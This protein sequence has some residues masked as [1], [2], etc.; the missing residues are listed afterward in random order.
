MIL[1]PSLSQLVKLVLLCLGK[2]GDRKVRVLVEFALS[3]EPLVKF[4]MVITLNLFKTTEIYKYHRLHFWLVKAFDESCTTI[5]SE[6]ILSCITYLTN[7]SNSLSASLYSW[8]AT[9]RTNPQITCTWSTPAGGKWRRDAADAVVGLSRKIS[10]AAMQGKYMS[11]P[12]REF[13]PLFHIYERLQGVWSF[14]KVQKV[15]SG[16]YLTITCAP[17]SK[18]TVYPHSG[19]SWP[20]GSDVVVATRV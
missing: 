3:S 7:L 12:T 18:L 14:S 4:L 1:T 8:S 11:T 5:T 17:L 6:E 19:A 16:T 9:T 15:D 13:V 2:F 10:T 20:R